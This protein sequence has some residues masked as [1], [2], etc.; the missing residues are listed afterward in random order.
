MVEDLEAALGGVYSLMAVEFQLPYV[1]VRLKQLEEAGILPQL[2]EG[3]V[4]PAIVTGVEALGR[5]NDK[6]R[7]IE[8]GQAIQSVMGPDALARLINPTEY[9]RRLITA[10]GIDEK[11]LLV[12]P[13]ELQQG[14]EQAQ[15]M[16][17]VEKLGPEAMKLMG[18]M[19]QNDPGAAQAA[20]APVMDAATN[21]V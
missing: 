13:Q 14:Q 18:G 15:T 5:G 20:L 19:V 17:L 21:A 3:T 1:K 9:L 16:G 11:G 4:K 12:D 7:L 10:S 8:L 2:P 6:T